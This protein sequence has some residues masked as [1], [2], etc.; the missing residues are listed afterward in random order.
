MVLEVPDHH[1]DKR[2]PQMVSPSPCYKHTVPCFCFCVSLAPN[3]WVLT[4]GKTSDWSSPAVVVFCLLPVLSCIIF[5]F[6]CLHMFL[7]PV[8]RRRRE[9]ENTKP[10]T[11]RDDDD[12]VFKWEIFPRRLL[13][14]FP[15]LELHS[16]LFAEQFFPFPSA[17]LGP[18]SARLL[19]DMQTSLSPVTQSSESCRE[20]GGQAGSKITVSRSE[21]AED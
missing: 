16:S 12:H 10:L 14:V 9:R 13:I 15:H 4:S 5:F 6:P 1:T 11:G 2:W 18:G 17:S 21:E 7:L 8:R 20:W 3:Q 19:K